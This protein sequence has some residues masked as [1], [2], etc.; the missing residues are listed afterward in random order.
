AE[1]ISFAFVVALQRLPARQRAALLLHDVLGFGPDEVATVLEATPGAVNSLLHRARQTMDES[2]SVALA[3]PDSPDVKA[4]L[5]RYIR[6][7]QLAD[8]AR[9]LETVSDDVRMS[10]PPLRNWFLGAADVA[11][12]VGNAIFGPAAGVGVRM[13]VGRVNGQ[14]AV[15]TYQPTPDGTW[16]ASGLQVLDVDRHETLISSI[17]SFLDPQIAI[18]CGFPAEL[19]AN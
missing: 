2:P 14:S 7:W 13:V 9:F 4:L 17:T 1:H 16:G 18:S 6:A 3:D 10:M 5:E 12:F 15:A 11:G 19:P 8:I